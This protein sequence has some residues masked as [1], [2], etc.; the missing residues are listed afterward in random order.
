MSK[1]IP[2]SAQGE[3]SEPGR[4][5]ATDPDQPVAAGHLAVAGVL[6][7]VGGVQGRPLGG[8][9][10]VGEVPAAAF[11]H[12]LLGPGQQGLGVEVVERSHI[13]W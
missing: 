11:D 6:A 8:E 7:G 12:A 5:V 13:T 4:T 3:L 10:E 9:V 2:S 1:A